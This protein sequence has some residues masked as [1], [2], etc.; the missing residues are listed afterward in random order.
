MDAQNLDIQ[1]DPAKLR[2]ARG[3]RPL[4][5]VAKQIGITEQYLSMI[6][7]GQRR[8][9][10]NV[11]AKLLILYGMHNICDFIKKPEDSLAIG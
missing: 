9:P 1:I 6:E 3:C 4:L 8:V 5:E 11:L 2:A 7:L 10:S